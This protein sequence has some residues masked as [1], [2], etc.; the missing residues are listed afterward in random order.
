MQRVRCAKKTMGLPLEGSFSRYLWLQFRGVLWMISG[1]LISVLL[2]KPC[3]SPYRR[4]F[5]LVRF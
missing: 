2:R 3:K 5:V 1:A 4:D